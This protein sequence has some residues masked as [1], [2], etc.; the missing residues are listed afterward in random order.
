[1][2]QSNSHTL[3]LKTNWSPQ[4]GMESVLVE[5]LNYATK[6][7]DFE[8][9]LSNS[10]QLSRFGKNHTF[11][12]PLIDTLNTMAEAGPLA[13]LAIIE[14]ASQMNHKEA[15]NLLVQ[16]LSANEPSVRRLACWKLEH[17]HPVKSALPTLTKQLC[18]GG[19]DTLHAHNTLARWATYNPDLIIQASM[20][21]L[22]THSAPL[23]RAR[24]VDLLGSLASSRITRILTVIAADKLEHT[25]VRIAAIGALGTR[26]DAFT[27]SV[28]MILSQIASKANE[29]GAYAQLALHDQAATQTPRASKGKGLKVCQLVL[30]QVDE[31]LSKGGRGETGGVASLLVSLADSLSEQGPIEQVMTIGLGS[32]NESL[33]NLKQSTS[34]AQAFGVVAAGDR[35]RPMTSLNAFEHLPAL[36]RSINRCLRRFP[37]IDIIHL[38]MLDAGTFAAAQVAKDLGIPVCFSFAPDPQN[39]VSGLQAKGA[40]TEKAFLEADATSHLW[41][42]ARMLETMSRTVGHV[43]LFPQPKCKLLLQDIRKELNPKTQ[44]CVTV[45]EG[46]D[47]KMMRNTERR[48]E[49]NQKQKDDVLNE[50][51]EKICLSRRHLPLL[52]SVGRFHPMKGMARIVEAWASN[53]SLYERC[54]L[55]LVGGNLSNPSTTEQAVMCDIDSSMALHNPPKAGLVMLG[56]RPRAQTAQLMVATQKGR[57]GFWAKGG[58]YV[59]GAPKE[60]FGLALIEALSIGLVVVAPSTGGP[61]TFVEHG[62][63]GILVAPKADLGLAITQGF[64]LVEQPGRSNKARSMVEQRYAIETMAKRLTDLYLTVKQSA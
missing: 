47:V 58:I 55:V 18:Q 2:Q 8:A 25:S 52:L 17:K 33:D 6:A 11:S 60:E 32:V 37:E 39:T 4:F 56:G 9:M 57:E 31:G 48:Y 45:A 44:H 1:M 50:L 23:K 30:A 43:A 59:D 40:L 10:S 27:E 26:A 62:D 21:A 42:R 12:Q 54:N 15:T 36:K 49:L 51:E 64:K 29:L 28:K 22:L 41:F 14:T 35:M 53:P 16:C 34:L 61:S 46:I 3:S 13:T 24:I 20:N 63:T 19:I 38:R 7:V 5:S